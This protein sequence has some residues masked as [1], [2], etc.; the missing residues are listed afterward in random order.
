[1]TVG[2]SLVSCGGSNSAL[3]G[4]WYLVEGAGKDMPD[5]VELLK[6][7]TGFAFSQAITWKT[8]KNRLYI[9]HPLLAMAFDY[10]MSGSRLDLAT[11]KG[12]KFA[13]MKPGGSSA[14]VGNWIPV[15]GE[16]KIPQNWYIAENL[17]LEREG[18]GNVD[19]D[20]LIWVAEKNKLW[21]IAYE[22]S[23]ALFDF[24]ISGSMLDV[25]WNNE[26]NVKLKKE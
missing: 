17:K 8:E 12:E 22:R 9:T 19:G 6:D 24:K 3:V 14:L 7:G 25:T 15:E 10:K 26:Q 13:Y 4:K 11:D 2:L 20:N 18:K 21:I 16:F 5:D 23:A 1:M